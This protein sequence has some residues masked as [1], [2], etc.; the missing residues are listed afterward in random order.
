MNIFNNSADNVAAPRPWSS[1]VPDDDNLSDFGR[2]SDATMRYR[3]D[4][5]HNSP[6]TPSPHSL[7]PQPTLTRRNIPPPSSLA[8]SPD[9]YGPDRSH[10]FTRLLSRHSTQPVR[11]SPRVRFD[12]EQLP[13]FA[14][15]RGPAPMAGLKDELALAA[16]KVTPGVDDTPYI[17]YALS[18]L[19]RDRS[20]NSQAQPHYS[21]Q[22]ASAYFNHLRRTRTVGEVP[23]RQLPVTAPEPDYTEDDAPLRRISPRPEISLPVPPPV[24]EARDSPVIS[25]PIG[26]AWDVKDPSSAHWVAVTEDMRQS[27]DPHGRTYPPLTYKPSILRPFSMMILMTLCLCMMAALI[28]CV[29]YSI[30]HHGLT[31]YP[32]SIYTAQFFAFRILPQLLG[33]IIL[34]YAQSIVNTS[35]RV[36]PFVSLADEDPQQRYLALFADLYP[37]SLLYPQLVGP[38][39]TM[40]FDIATWFALFTVPL[41]SAS[42]TCI[43][44]SDRWVWAPVPVVIWILVALYSLLVLSTA[45]VMV[46][47]FGKWTGFAWD[48][49]SIGHL[50]PLLNRSNATS[51]FD[52]HNLSGARDDFQTDL[53][54][55]WFDRL[56]YW[57]S[58]DMITGGIWY[59]IGAVGARGNDA[60]MVADLRRDGARKVSLD[61]EAT[62]APGN[63]RRVYERYLPLCIQSVPLIMYTVLC[64]LLV[65][66]LLVVSFVPQTRIDYGFR[67][68]LA[69]RPG[70]DAFSA[71]NFLYAFLPSVVGMLF[72]MLFQP[73]DMAFRRLQPWADLGQLHGAT[74]SKS[75]LAD[76][77]ACLP[78]QASWRAARNGHWR[79][80]LLSIMA[81]AFVAIPVLG[82]GL[83]M[84]FARD[85]GQVRM[86]PSMP[87]FGVLVAFL[88][89]YVG[90][91]SLA[92]PRRAQ[93]EL[94][95]PVT[96][97]AALMSLCSARELTQD[98]AFRSVRSRE[99]LEGRLGVGRDAR[100]ETVWFYGVVAGRDEHRVSVR[101]MQRYTE[102]PRVRTVEAMV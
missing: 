69:A 74:A 101:R 23:S 15:M 12:E 46:F 31:P 84:A 40:L 85:D 91:L 67:P 89:L 65:V 94:P 60:R 53:R 42:F 77:A 28:F 90:C 14:G 82:G 21:P 57:R 58:G 33:A 55:R 51:S 61:S 54:D 50:L 43:Y 47:W 98:S 71:A 99:D 87:V 56:G 95:R 48:V 3:S 4:Q 5:A 68:L 45:I 97:I 35:T 73:I 93:F 29:Q 41:L 72:W 75:I 22:S 37:K 81:Q 1:Q 66:A 16:G 32:G 8:S 25:I 17:Q 19:T 59:S 100:E 86:Y 26:D 10:I 11:T 20:S 2:D 38:W 9:L 83:F 70:N 96:S 27:L 52:P 7:S 76:Y 24:R 63:W 80:A 79:V 6:S 62:A 18:A 64:A 78:L 44:K 30:R 49:R 13:I 39:Q 102:K 92:V 36:L 34:I 88:L